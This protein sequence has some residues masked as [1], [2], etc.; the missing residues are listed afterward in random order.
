LAK[1]NQGPFVVSYFG[2]GSVEVW[3]GLLSS[4]AAA[5]LTNARSS[6]YVSMNCL[7]GF[8]HD[9]YT[10]SL[11][12][13]LLKAPGGGA[14]AVWAS[15][16]L[17]SF[18]PQAVL[19]REFLK[20]LTRTSLGEAATAAKQAIADA[21]ARR[22][23]ILFGDP[24]LFGTPQGT[25]PDAA[26]GGP[27]GPAQAEGGVADGP[28]QAE[29]DGPAQAAAGVADGPSSDRKPDASRA[30]SG[31]GCSCDAAEDKGLS[32]PLCGLAVFGLLAFGRRR[33]RSV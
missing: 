17:T 19:N 20:R 32:S 25:A 5:A 24:T 21:D 11:A 30:T 4:D 1:L 7:N 22:T 12:E 6:I 18:E 33:A 16:T 29:A 13:A 3:D 10:E 8:F 26:A 23:W 15:S 27:D 2:H 28:A 31:G 14:V 9:L